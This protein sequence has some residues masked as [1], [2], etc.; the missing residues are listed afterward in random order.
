[1]KDRFYEELER[2]FH[3]F[4]N[5]HTKILLKHFN[6]KVGMEDIFKPTT[7][8][9]RLHKISNESGVG[10]VNFTTSKNLTVKSITFPHSNIHKFTWTSPDGKNDTQIDHILI[11]RGQHSSVPDI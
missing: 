6:A 8:N 5:Y 2:V 9:G 4:S 1:M 3:K 10:V 7:G 11:G